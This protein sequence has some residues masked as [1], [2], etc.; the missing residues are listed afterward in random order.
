MKKD[1]SD[2]WELGEK[3][4]VNFFSYKHFTSIMINDKSVS[5]GDNSFTGNR[6]TVMGVTSRQ[7]CTC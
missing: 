1:T 4:K 3:I 6:T 2:N 5:V 7:K